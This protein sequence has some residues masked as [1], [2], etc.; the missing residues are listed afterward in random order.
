LC[1]GVFVLVG[2]DF[3]AVVDEPEGHLG[4][5]LRGFELWFGSVTRHY[6]LSTGFICLFIGGSLSYDIVVS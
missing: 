3:G 2:E 6:T 5:Y 1:E 4:G